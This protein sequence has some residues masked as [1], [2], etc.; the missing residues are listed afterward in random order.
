[1]GNT[2]LQATVNP[3]VT[4]LGPIESAAKRISIMG[5]ANKLAWPVAPMFLALVMRKECK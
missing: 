4:I 1:M 5:I 2:F 3:Y